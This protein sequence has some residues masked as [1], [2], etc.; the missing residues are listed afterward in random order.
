MSAAKFTPGPWKL[1]D[2]DGDLAVY[3]MTGDVALV[4][5]RMARL[6]TPD[7]ASMEEQA[8]AHLIVAAPEMYAALEAEMQRLEARSFR[9][10]LGPHY[11]GAGWVDDPDRWTDADDFQAWSGMRA[12]LARARGEEVKP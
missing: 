12:L 3:V 11:A 4:A 2:D 9:H 8:N 10:H 7:S 1:D 6:G 5:S